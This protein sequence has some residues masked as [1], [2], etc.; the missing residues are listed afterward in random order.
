MPRSYAHLSL[1]GRRKIARWHDAKMPVL[2]IAHRL[3]L[4]RA[5]I[6]RELKRDRFVDAELQDFSGYYAL[7]AQS[8]SEARRAGLRKL[9][10][11]PCPPQ[12]DASSAP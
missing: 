2:E 12:L 7:N 1:E 10:P 3:G 4:Y 8:K 6:H 11:A 9:L 5:T